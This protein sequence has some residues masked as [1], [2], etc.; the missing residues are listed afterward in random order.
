MT[1]RVNPE[2]GFQ[3]TFA[4]VRGAILATVSVDEADR[5][6]GAWRIASQEVDSSILMVRVYR[7]VLAEADEMLTPTV[8]L[9]SESDVA[10]AARLLPWQLAVYLGHVR[11]IS[12]TEATMK[13]R[14][15]RFALSSD[16][17]NA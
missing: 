11:T 7:R 4:Q 6:A 14:G 12:E 17:W 15:I 16:D 10:R 13:A 8:R 5:I 1:V 2:Q 3:H 9:H